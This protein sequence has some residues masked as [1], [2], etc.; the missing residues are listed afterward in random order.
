ML[1]LL[2]TSRDLQM[3]F[4]AV[5]HLVNGLN[6]E[7][8]LMLRVEKSLICLVGTWRQTMSII[9]QWSILLLKTLIR[10]KASRFCRLE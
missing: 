10:N 5:M 8:L 1:H 4:A 6:L 3:L 2:K 9:E 7:T